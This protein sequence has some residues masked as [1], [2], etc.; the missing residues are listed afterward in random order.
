MKFVKRIEIDGYFSLDEVTIV[1]NA[2]NLLENIT[3]EEYDNLM[4]YYADELSVDRSDAENDYSNLVELL[5]N[6]YSI[7]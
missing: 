7:M 3:E 2:I 5:H 4:D 6:F 1:R